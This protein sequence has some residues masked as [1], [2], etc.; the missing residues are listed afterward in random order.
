[1]KTAFVAIVLLVAAT[2]AFAQFGKL[3]ELAGKAG[4]LALAWKNLTPG[5]YIGR[6]TFDGASAPTFVSVVVA[7]AGTA[8]VPPASEDPKK[9]KE[10]GKVVNDDLTRTPDNSI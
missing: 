9:K 7:P 5:S 8:A 2:P 6:V 4:K 10:T 3:G 1:M